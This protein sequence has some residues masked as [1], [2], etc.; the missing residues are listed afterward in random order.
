MSVDLAKRFAAITKAAGTKTWKRESLSLAEVRWDTSAQAPPTLTVT[1]TDTYMLATR[2]AEV[3]RIDGQLGDNHTFTINARDFAK[4]ITQL[5]KTKT[6]TALFEVD[7]DR[8]ALLVASGV[9]GEDGYNDTLPLVNAHYPDWEQLLS[10]RVYTYKGTLPALDPRKVALLMS[11]SGDTTGT[12]AKAPAQLF[13]THDGNKAPP[14][15]SSGAL[16]D[17]PELQPVGFIQETK[18]FGTWR[19]LLMPVRV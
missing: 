1:C 19:G 12:K 17:R 7:A 6:T 10:G 4:S 15:R 9:G 5:T 11:T 3:E 8:G 13:V 16:G 18:D 14:P 2:Q